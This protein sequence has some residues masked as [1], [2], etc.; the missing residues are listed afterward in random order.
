MSA[1]GT[2]GRGGLRVI[3]IAG[4][5]GGVGKTVLA[6][7]LAVE[8]ARRGDRVLLIDAD[9]GAANAHLLLGVFPDAG[10]RDVAGGR[11]PIED[12][13]FETTAGPTL[14]SG[15]GHEIESE[16]LDDCETLALLGA[17]DS[18][19]ERFDAVVIDTS[20]G[21]G[22]NALFFA[23]AA[24]EVVLVT[25]PEPTALAD[26]Y[27]SARALCKRS[28][29]SRLGLVVNHAFGPGIASAVHDR[30]QTL[31]GHFLGAR[32]DLLGWL[33]FDPL[34][35][36]AVM[37]GQPIV[38]TRPTSLVSRR[39]RTL[40]QDL[41]ALA[42]ESPLAAERSALRFFWSSLPSRYGVGGGATVVPGWAAGLPARGRA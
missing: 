26:T 23:G 29:R 8:L 21:V 17:L 5:K 10:I 41:S 1:L 35:H 31:V 42:C 33:P 3:A 20:A 11:V 13:L 22:D 15:L 39:M 34:V 14:L 25:T 2:A 37:V 27:A 16:T 12:A 19:G 18:I 6:V 36:D 24:D 32:I 28:G 30:L 4:G 7:N 9:I 40:A 38:A